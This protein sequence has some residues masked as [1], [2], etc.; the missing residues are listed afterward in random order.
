MLCA[1]DVENDGVF[2]LFVE[3]TTDTELNLS[4]SFKNDSYEEEDESSDLSEPGLAVSTSKLTVN[5]HTKQ[6]RD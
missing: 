3:Q 5:K 1:R 6:G 4:N 2:G